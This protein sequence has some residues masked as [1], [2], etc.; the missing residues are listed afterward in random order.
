MGATTET[1]NGNVVI[2]AT[3]DH[4]RMVIAELLGDLGIGAAPVR[5]VEVVA[6]ELTTRQAKKHLKEKGYRVESAPYFNK[7]VELHGVVPQKKGKENWYKLSEL[8]KIPSRI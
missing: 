3:V 2:V 6:T 5:N 4:L 8:S 7:L 1:L